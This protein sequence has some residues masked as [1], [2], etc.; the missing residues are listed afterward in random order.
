MLSRTGLPSKYE[1]EIDA[2]NSCHQRDLLCVRLL[3][4][5]FGER[6]FTGSSYDK[7]REDYNPL[8]SFCMGIIEEVSFFF[9]DEEDPVCG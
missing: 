3:S 1:Q 4:T 9:F 2:A 8:D 7:G 6:D 5:I